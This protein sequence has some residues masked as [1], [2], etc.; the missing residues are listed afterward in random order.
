M[1]DDALRI[2]PPHLMGQALREHDLLMNDRTKAFRAFRSL[3]R[4]RY[5]SERQSNRMRA[6]RYT[7]VSTDPMIRIEVNRIRGFVTSIVGALFS[8]DVKVSYAPAPDGKGNAELS[9]IAMNRVLHNKKMALRAIDCLRQATVY[10]GAALKVMLDD[11]VRDPAQKVTVRVIPWTELVL[12]RDTRD[13]DDARFIGHAYYI[14]YA[15]ALR[16]FGRDR[17]FMT[18]M[19]DDQGRQRAAEA[20]ARKSK[21]QPNRVRRPDTLATT[22]DRTLNQA[23]V[24]HAAP[25]LGD[26]LNAGFVRV[27]EVYNLV[28]DFVIGE[29]DPITG[30]PIPAW[31]PVLDANGNEVRARGRYE[32]YLPDEPTGFDHPV[33]VFPMPLTTDGGEPLP[34]IAPLILNADPE[35]PMH[36]LST[37][38]TVYDQLR[39]LILERTWKA[40]AVKKNARLMIAPKGVLTADEKDKWAQGVDGELIEYDPEAAGAKGQSAH[41]VMAPIQLP[42]VNLDNTYYTKEI[43]EDIARGTNMPQF[44]SGAATGASATE[45]NRL[46]AYAKNGMGLLSLMRDL[47]LMD[48]QLL[49]RRALISALRSAGPTATIP[50]TW[51]N[52]V[53]H[54]TVADLDAEFGVD[55]KSPPFSEIEEDRNRQTFVTVMG[56]LKPAID[57]WV[58][59]GD[60]VAGAIVDRAVELFK[61]PPEFTSAA[62]RKLAGP[63]GGG[64]PA[65]QARGPGAGSALPGRGSQPGLPDAGAPPNP[66]GPVPPEVQNG[67]IQNTAAAQA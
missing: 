40:N 5:W 10:D 43:E 16:K 57:A 47:W 12:D 18:T 56:F 35:Y 41:Q 48:V 42:N 28:D 50:V 8:D 29:A 54:V 34:S 19:L 20:E 25:G 65:A 49:L 2:L 13:R 6:D 21:R 9:Q 46:D 37:V 36:G 22:Y 17:T 45:V 24:M 32:T 58:V 3:W 38:E 15:D 26:P 51:R 59:K 66:A 33:R 53:H 11:R 63:P 62:L 1:Q 55:I 14:P 31:Q 7:D 30:V 64:E 27:F 39:E 60:P 61:L 4:S 23:E 67:T 44:T 52:E